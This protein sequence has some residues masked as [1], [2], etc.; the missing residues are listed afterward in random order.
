MAW[1]PFTVRH[2][3]PASRGEDVEE[4]SRCGSIIENDAL[5]VYDPLYDPILSIL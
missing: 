1:R 3:L 2:A 4:I 5:N